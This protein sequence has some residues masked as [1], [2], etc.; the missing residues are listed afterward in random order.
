[1]AE[2]TRKLKQVENLRTLCESG[3]RVSRFELALQEAVFRLSG[4]F[5]NQLSIISVWV[6]GQQFLLGD[7]VS[8]LKDTE[9]TQQL[10]SAR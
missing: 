9:T 1:M 5:I 7:Q 2:I 10:C 3:D 8:G 4:D 6:H